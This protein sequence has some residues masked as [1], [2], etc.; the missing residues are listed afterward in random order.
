MMG[1]GA[2][3]KTQVFSFSWHRIAIILILTLA[4]FLRFYQLDKSVWMQSG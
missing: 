1:G 4:L 3:R 2:N